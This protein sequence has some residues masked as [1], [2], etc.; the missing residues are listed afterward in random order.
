MVAA[1]GM[2]GSP[3]WAQ[4]LDDVA[5]T[6]VRGSPRDRISGRAGAVVVTGENWPGGH[7]EGDEH[8]RVYEPRA[9]VIAEHDAALARYQ[10]FY[11]NTQVQGSGGQ[12]SNAGP[13]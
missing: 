6:E 9:D 12:V 13:R 2:S 11:R 7:E 5:G 3:L 8:I 10:L 4:L 1:G